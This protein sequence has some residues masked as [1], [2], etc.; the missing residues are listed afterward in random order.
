M[1]RFLQ[2]LFTAGALAMMIFTKGAV[3]VSAPEPNTIL[4]SPESYFSLSLF[5]GGTFPPFITAVLTCV[6]L[7][8][9]FAAL[10]S[11][12]A[13]IALCVL[14]PVTFIVS[15]LH[16]VPHYS[17]LGYSLLG[18]CISLCLLLSAVFAIAAMFGRKPAGPAQRPP[19]MQ[20]PPPPPPPQNPM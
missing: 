16:R 17:V 6:L 10:K 1:K 13:R 15:L 4:Y 19:Q 8:L 11:K 9:S 12:K 3:R 2:L 14:A 18:I 7:V 5:F 20:Q